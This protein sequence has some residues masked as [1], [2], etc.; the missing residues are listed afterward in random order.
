MLDLSHLPTSP[1]YGGNQ[2]IFWGSMTQVGPL[3]YVWCK[4]R[5]C[6][7][8]SF[9]AIGQ[10]GKGA[11]GGVGATA[12]G[13]VGG[14]SGSMEI[15][16]WPVSFLPD[17]LYVGAG[18]GGSGTPIDSLVTD[19]SYGATYNAIQDY[20][21]AYISGGGAI[22]NV[23][24]AGAQ[25]VIDQLSF[26]AFWTFVSGNA[27]ANGGTTSGTAGSATVASATAD[28]AGGGG[29]GGMS[30]TVAGAGGA[31]TSNAPTWL[32]SSPGG[33]A[34]T[35]GVNGGKGGS[36]IFLPMNGL[37]RLFCGGGGGG[38]AGFPTATTS[39]GGDGGKG[40]PGC[41]GGGGGA[42]VTGKTAGKGGQGGQGL[43]II[44]WI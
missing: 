26:K 44:Q 28:I 27:G 7:L 18:A 9:I 42:A 15:T 40:A 23:V 6:N 36:G 33:A 25:S 41:G 32:P 5:G 4:P 31:S 2:E 35:S 21:N 1:L 38:G 3:P 19:K 34:G 11:D 30:S 8:V 16:V 37:T 39:N 24:T 22:G 17:I 20:W 43:V 12:A 13:G 10:G 14:G 29:G